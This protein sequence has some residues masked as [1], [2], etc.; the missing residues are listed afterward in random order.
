MTGRVGL[1]RVRRFNPSR[2]PAQHDGD[3]RRKILSR[4]VDVTPE[5]REALRGRRA[6]IDQFL[7]CGEAFQIVLGGEPMESGVKIFPREGHDATEGSMGRAANIP[8]KHLRDGS[9]VAETAESAAYSD[10]H[11]RRR[12]YK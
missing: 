8:E 10:R 12:P 3:F 6:K 11:L 5:V 4:E 7:F 2:Q 9:N 1:A